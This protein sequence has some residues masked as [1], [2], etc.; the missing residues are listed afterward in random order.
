MV[1]CALNRNSMLH[2]AHSD[3][4]GALGGAHSVD[5]KHRKLTSGKGIHSLRRGV[6]AFYSGGMI[7]DFG[8]NSPMIAA[9]SGSLFPA[10]YAEMKKSGSDMEMVISSQLL[11]P[12]ENA[13]SDLSVFDLSTDSMSSVEFTGSAVQICSPPQ[14]GQS[15]CDTRCVFSDK[16]R[17]C[18]LISSLLGRWIESFSTVPA[19]FTIFN[20]QSAVTV[21]DFVNALLELVDYL[22]NGFETMVLCLAYVRRIA[23]NSLRLQWENVYRLLLAASLAAVKFHDDVG[24]SN[25]QFAKLCGLDIKDVRTLECTFMG[26]VGFSLFVAE[27]EF[28]LIVTELSTQCSLQPGQA[29]A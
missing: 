13:S 18:S 26:L 5:F 17:A 14:P 1:L 7:Y 22:E 9:E 4:R 12:F 21:K 15:Y 25:K 23:A 2:Q 10:E 24:I 29:Q 28:E 6:E 3:R 27:A 8:N 19:S 11:K 20:G 16:A